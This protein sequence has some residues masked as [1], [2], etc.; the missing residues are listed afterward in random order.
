MLGETISAIGG[1]KSA[2]DILQTILK[3]KN[4]SDRVAALADLQSALIDI[5]QQ[6][7]AMQSKLG[8]LQD[9]TIRL[10]RENEAMKHRASDLSR[11]QLV[12]FPE[13]GAIAYELKQEQRGKDE[14]DHYLC[15]NCF[16][17]GVKAILQEAGRSLDCQSCLLKIYRQEMPPLRFAS[18]DF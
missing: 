9:E 18:P 12:K 10:R 3:A 7:L 13:T 16:G 15:A 6:A 8:E 2:I 14:I 17:K 1:L 4:E 11:Y 5:Q